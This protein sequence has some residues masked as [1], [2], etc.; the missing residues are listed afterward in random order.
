VIIKVVT[1]WGHRRIRKKSYAKG[2]ERDYAY[3][4]GNKSKDI[5]DTHHHTYEYG[6]GKNGQETGKHL[7]GEHQ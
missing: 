6:L 5:P 1:T 4:A 7:P 3:N 2:F